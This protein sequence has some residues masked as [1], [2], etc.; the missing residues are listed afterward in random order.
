M[1]GKFTTDQGDDPASP[2][3]Y[4][5]RKVLADMAGK[6]Q[7]ASAKDLESAEIARV[8]AA[9]VELLQED[10]QRRVAALATKETAAGK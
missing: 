10:S 4:A 6:L 9:A 7:L 1:L 2:H 5:N 8:Q 3:S